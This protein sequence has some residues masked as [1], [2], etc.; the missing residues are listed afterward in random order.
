MVRENGFVV[1]SALDWSLI[2]TTLPLSIIFFFMGASSAIFGNWQLKAGTRA[3]LFVSSLMFGGGFILGSIGI[4]THQ[5]WLLYLGYGFLSGCALGIAYT[6][7]LQVLIEW[8]PDRKG[9]ASGMVVGGFGSGAIAFTAF[10]PYLT[11][12]FQKL[13]EYAG[14]FDAVKT[15][16]KNGRLFIEQTNGGLREVVLAHT[17]DLAKFQNTLIEGFYY[18]GTGNTGTAAALATC[19]IIYT[20]IMVTS[21]FLIKRPS[22]GYRPVGYIPP[23]NSNIP[24]ANLPGNVHSNS[25]MKTPQ[26]WFLMSTLYCLATGGFGI[27]SVAKPMM[28]EVFG[29]NMPKVVTASFAATFVLLLSTG[30]LMGRILWALLSDKIGRRATFSIFTLGSIPLYLALPSL[31]GGVVTYSSLAYLYGF[32]GCT[33]LSISIM[34]GA[35]AIL[36]AYEADLYGTKYIGPIH[37]K[38]LLATSAAA[39]SGP[40]LLLTLRSRS[41]FNAIK[42]LLTK[43]SPEKFREIFGVDISQASDL[44]QAKTININNLMKIVPEGIPNPTPFLYDTTMYSMAAIM[45]VAAVSHYMV[46]PVKKEF[47]ERND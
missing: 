17:A 38:F 32:I 12:K 16:T 23:T 39:L 10:F 40:P 44:I 28:L 9:L 43:V 30:N 31:V 7:P 24:G 22:P 41:E 46:R 8:F 1:S 20:G 19:G 18:I 13:P 6:P 47:F 2:Q 45:T 37:A 26:Y 33:V 34:G 21:A 11:Q 15:I 25:V 36:P 29:N 14:S 35:Y 4:A 42:E 27:F 5:L 3:T